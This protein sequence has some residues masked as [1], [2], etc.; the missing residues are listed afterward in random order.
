MTRKENPYDVTLETLDSIKKKFPSLKNLL[1]KKTAFLGFDGFVDY[2]YTL[3]KS[4]KSLEE[5]EKMESM[6]TLAQLISEIS[7]SSTNIEIILKRKVSGGFVANTCKAMNGLGV[8]VNVIGAFGYPKINEVFHDFLT[9][10]KINVVSFCNPA[11]TIG[12]EFHDGKIMLSNFENLYKINWKFIVDRVGIQALMDNMMPSDIIGMGYW[13]TIPRFEN[14]WNAFI[15]QICP[16]MPRLEKKL[17]LIDLA[18]MKKKSKSEIL[19][20]VKV[21]KKLNEF[22][23]VVLSLN[24]QEAIDISKALD[25]VKALDPEKKNFEDF[26]KGGFSINQELNLSY[27]VIHSPHFATISTPRDHYWVYEAFTSRPSYTT[28]AG[29]H[30]NAGM[31]VGLSCDLSPPEAILLGNALTAV[32]VRTGFSPKF[33]DLSYFIEN[34]LT[35]LKEDIPKFPIN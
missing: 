19:R 1:S 4:R 11:L 29:D 3:A 24:D 7:R 14:I 33:R 20:M 32:F 27:L 22:I 25:G 23:P 5:W 13:S 12:L 35:Y 2:L 16:S 31:V 10:E 18:D 30:F 21:I 15:E 28:S 34:Y 17:F 26:I 6:K 8:N 9:N